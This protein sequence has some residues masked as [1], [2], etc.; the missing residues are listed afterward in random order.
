M[1]VQRTVHFEGELSVQIEFLSQ[2]SMPK[3]LFAK[4]GNVTVLSHAKGT[5]YK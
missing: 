3:V 2:N 5:L 1:Q 4:A